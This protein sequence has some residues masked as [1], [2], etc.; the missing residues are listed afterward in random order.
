MMLA[1]DTPP[2][3]LHET[4]LRRPLDDRL[5]TSCTHYADTCG[6]AAA[7]RVARHAGFGAGCDPGRAGIRETALPFDRSGN[8]VGPHFGLRGLRIEPGS[9]LRC[10]CTRWSVEDNEQRCAVYATVSGP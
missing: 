7:D 1:S 5:Y 6:I 3:M 8:N 10:H 4:R 2:T 9:F